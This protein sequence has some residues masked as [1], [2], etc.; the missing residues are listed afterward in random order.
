MIVADANLVAW[1]LLPTPDSNTARAVFAKD[2]DWVAPL[3]LRSELT[4]VFAQ[5]VQAG[6][7]TLADVTRLLELADDLVTAGY[8]VPAA[9]VLALAA[10]SRCS[11]YDCEYVAL[12]ESLGVP[13]V[14]ADRQVLR[15]FPDVAV[16][17][18][19]F[20]DV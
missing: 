14:T 16:R 12:A 19:A 8:R 4:S 18:A 15:A 1:I 10:A 11:A 3:L 5:Y 9:R 2:P 17:P 20:L 7:A 13:L 6:K